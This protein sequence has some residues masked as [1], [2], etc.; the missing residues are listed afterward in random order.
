MHICVCCHVYHMLHSPED[1]QHIK[2]S[3]VFMVVMYVCVHHT[4][5]AKYCIAGTLARFLIWRIGN[6]TE[7]HQI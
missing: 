3:I 4:V 1:P 5:V 7:S 2:E 6:F